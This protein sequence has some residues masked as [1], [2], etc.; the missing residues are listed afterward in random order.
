MGTNSKLNVQFVNR[1]WVQLGCNGSTFA[2]TGYQSTWEATRAQ[3]GEAGILVDFTGGKIGASFNNP[4]AVMQYTR[5]FLNQLEPVLPGIAPEWNRRAV[6]NYWTGYPWTLGSYSY[7]KVGQDTKIAGVAG[8][9]EGNCFF[10]GE[11]TSL[12]S[13]GFLN[14]GVESG[15]RAAK[16]ILFALKPGIIL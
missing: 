1:H 9:P 14:G 12:D 4:K 10:A 5:R 2:D 7:F 16:E 6:L 8:E 13:Q 3:P 15:E 11:Q